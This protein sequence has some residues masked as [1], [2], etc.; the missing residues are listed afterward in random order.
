VTSLSIRKY[1]GFFHFFPGRERGWP[2]RRAAIESDQDSIARLRL[3]RRCITLVFDR[4]RTPAEDKATVTVNQHED[5]TGIELYID[6]FQRVAPVVPRE[7]LGFGERRAV[8]WHLSW[9]KADGA[10]L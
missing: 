10:R 1:S 9:T 7:P 2:A 8:Y 5:A 4:A 6:A 3:D